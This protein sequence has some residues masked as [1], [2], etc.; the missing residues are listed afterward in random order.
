LLALKVIAERCASAP[1]GAV[2]APQPMSDMN[3]RRLMGF[4]KAKDQE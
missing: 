3:A 1:S 2:T 4:T